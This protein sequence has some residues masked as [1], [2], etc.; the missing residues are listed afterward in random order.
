MTS[1][2]RDA[3]G[4]PSQSKPRTKKPPPRKPLADQLREAAVADG[5]SDAALGRACGIDPGALGRFLRDERSLTLRV[6]DRLAAELG[7]SL[8]S[9]QA[10]DARIDRD[11]Q[12]Q[13]RP[14]GP[15]VEH[16]E[17]DGVPIARPSRPVGDEQASNHAPIGG[18]GREHDGSEVG[19]RANDRVRRELIERVDDPDPAIPSLPRR[20]GDQAEPVGRAVRE[21]DPDRPGRDQVDAAEQRI[22]DP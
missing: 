16:R 5:R 21:P 11:R 20:L 17:Y 1:S 9:L 4:K 22:E 15:R 12:P 3:S 2:R 7:L 19:F 6:A 10:K 8:S 18:G 13:R 14:G